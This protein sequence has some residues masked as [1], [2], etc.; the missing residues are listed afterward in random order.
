MTN[1]EAKAEIEKL[2][3]QAADDSDFMA[4]M[5]IELDK[6]SCCCCDAGPGA[7]AAAPPMFWPELIRCII[8]RAVKDKTAE[9]TAEVA[10]LKAELANP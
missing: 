5:T 8:A 2:K 1:E 7:H 9:L 10:R 6:F 3:E 4:F